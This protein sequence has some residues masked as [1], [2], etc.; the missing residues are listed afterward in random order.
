MADYYSLIQ[1][2]VAGLA[3]PTPENRRAIYE[4]AMAALRMQ[5]ENLDP[6]LTPAEIMREQILLEETIQRVELEATRVSDERIEEIINPPAPVEPSPIAAVGLDEEPVAPV[7][8]VAPVMPLRTTSLAPSIQ[9]K[10]T[11]S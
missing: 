7:A 3:E 5:L 8:P 10:R 2:A 11:S 1:R 4:R 9:G 6:P